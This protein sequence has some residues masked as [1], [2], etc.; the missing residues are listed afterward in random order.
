M[1]T[2]RPLEVLSLQDVGPL[3]SQWVR[4]PFLAPEVDTSFK[5]Q[6]KSCVNVTF[7]C[8][9][10]FTPTLLNFLPSTLELTSTDYIT[11]IYQIHPNILYVH[12]MQFTNIYL[13][14]LTYHLQHLNTY[15]F[16]RTG[17]MSKMWHFFEKNEALLCL[18]GLIFQVFSTV[19]KSLSVGV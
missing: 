4:K 7:S 3:V 1:Q 14:Y 13:I 6:S 2:F 15:I 16:L 8:S 9:A 5:F 11:N 19:L 17:K 10:F 18:N 12:F